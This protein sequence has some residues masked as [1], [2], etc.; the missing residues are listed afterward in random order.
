MFSICVQCMWNV[1][2]ASESLHV[3]MLHAALCKIRKTLRQAVPLNFHSAFSLR[4]NLIHMICT[5][6]DSRFSSI[7][8]IIRAGSCSRQA[9]HLPRAAK[10]DGKRKSRHR[11]RWA[12]KVTERCSLS[13]DGG[14]CSTSQTFSGLI[15]FYNIQHC[16]TS[17]PSPSP[18]LKNYDA[19]KCSSWLQKAS[20]SGC[21]R[22]PIGSLG[23]RTS[24]GV[25]SATRTQA[26]FGSSPYQFILFT[27]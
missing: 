1:S 15:F 19:A 6:R 25:I 10:L 9:R 2:R 23:W 3:S 22:R 18:M 4:E 21:N 16:S 14:T 20:Y 12:K 7:R 26:W 17:H 5:L 24:E 27:F 11:A 13:G 8:M